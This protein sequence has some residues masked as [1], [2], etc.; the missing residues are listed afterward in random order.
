MGPDVGREVT[1]ATQIFALKR[2]LFTRDLSTADIHTYFLPQTHAFNQNPLLFYLHTYLHTHILML[3]MYVYL[4][5][6]CNSFF[7][8][9][10]LQTPSPFVLVIFVVFWRCPFFI[11]P[12]RLPV[13]FR[14]FS[15][16][17][18]VVSFCPLVEIVATERVTKTLKC[19]ASPLIP[20]Y[21]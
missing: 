19:V 5:T 6:F 1:L 15:E 20:W 4:T 2:A 9:L 17:S 18:V 12:F 10:C 14:R 21:F 13:M 7:F 11:F 8:W 3:H 16:V